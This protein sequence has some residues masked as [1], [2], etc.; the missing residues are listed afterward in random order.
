MVWRSQALLSRSAVALAVAKLGTLL[1]TNLLLLQIGAVLFT[2]GSIISYLC[3]QMYVVDIY[4]R[5]AASA[6][7][8]STFLRSLAAFS[9]PLFMPYLFNYLGYG[10]G[11]STLGLAAI[12]LGIP[13]P[14][15]FWR[16]GATLRARSPFAASG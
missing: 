13:A 9:F 2:S 11:S 16:Y 6:T 14:F 3:T 4:T 12:V 15:L 10:W 5:Y 7:A 8:A 1:A